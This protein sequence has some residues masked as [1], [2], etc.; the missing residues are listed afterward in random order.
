MATCC[1]TT[2]IEYIS[3]KEKAV[4]YGAG[5]G[6]YLQNEKG[7]LW[8][9]LSSVPIERAYLYNNLTENLQVVSS[10]NPD[11]Y[12]SVY[13]IDRDLMLATTANLGEKGSTKLTF[14][15]PTLGLVGKYN[16]TEMR[17]SDPNN[18]TTEKIGTT[19]DCIIQVGPLDKYE[20]RGYKFN[21]IK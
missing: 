15:M 12:T 4:A 11:F 19:D 1:G 16:I 14:D 8:K 9:I 20:I 10:T 6:T 13:K 5:L 2:P 18:F 7:V 21:R 3:P 17:G